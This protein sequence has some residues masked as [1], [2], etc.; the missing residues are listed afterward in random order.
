MNDRIIGKSKYNDTPH[1]IASVGYMY[2]KRYE[3]KST[4]YNGNAYFGKDVKYE[5]GVV[6]GNVHIKSDETCVLELHMNKDE[7][8]KLGIET[9]MG[10]SIC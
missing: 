2:N 8:E 6:L 9:G 1:S 10:V 5:N 7:A 3:P 4:S